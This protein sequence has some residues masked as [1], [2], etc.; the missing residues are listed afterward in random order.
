MY[1]HITKSFIHKMLNCLVHEFLPWLYICLSQALAPN[2]LN[3]SLMNKFFHHN[4]SI[5]IVQ[6]IFY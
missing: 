3:F 1:V 2:V 6:R 5:I 4:K